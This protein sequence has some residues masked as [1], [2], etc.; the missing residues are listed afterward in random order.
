MKKIIDI[1]MIG[2]LIFQLFYVYAGEVIH[3]LSG[4]SLIMTVGMHIYLERYFFKKKMNKR[5]KCFI[6]VSFILLVCLVALA[7]TGL[8]FKGMRWHLYLTYIVLLTMMIHI[9]F[10]KL[11]W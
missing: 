6:V 11:G 7:L 8:F 2:L 3:I 9:F 4:I 10:M 5:D 1:F